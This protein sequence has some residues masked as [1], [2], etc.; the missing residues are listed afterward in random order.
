MAHYCQWI[1][2]GF[3]TVLVFLVLI[4]YWSV[5]LKGA[6]NINVNITPKKLFLSDSYIN[7]VSIL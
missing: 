1:A 6:L 2:N 5:S 4:I 7:N 3:T